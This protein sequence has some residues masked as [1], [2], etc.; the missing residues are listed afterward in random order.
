MTSTQKVLKTL[1]NFLVGLI[2]KESKFG[3]LEELVQEVALSYFESIGNSENTNL[4]KV[5]NTARSRARRFTQDKNHFAA[6]LDAAPQGAAQALGLGDV[7]APSR[8]QEAANATKSVAENLGCSERHARRLIAK[9]KEKA[10][11]QGDFFGMEGG[12]L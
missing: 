7:I 11:G 2:K 5:F 4:Q 6:P 12:V 9:N 1:P 8:R 10:T 3:D